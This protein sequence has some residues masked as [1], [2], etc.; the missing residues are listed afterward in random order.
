MSI[1][2]T[3]V[4]DITIPEGKVK[5]ITRKSDGSVVWEKPVT[6]TCAVTIYWYPYYGGVPTITYHAANGQVSFEPN[7]SNNFSEEKIELECVVG[8]YIYIG[9]D[10]FWFGSFRIK[11]GNPVIEITEAY[12]KAQILVND[13]CEILM[14]GA[15]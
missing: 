12:R 3:G 8:S 9:G 2:F 14:Y 15:V 13:E 5:K 6:E 1:D 11:A 10:D 4:T 7:F